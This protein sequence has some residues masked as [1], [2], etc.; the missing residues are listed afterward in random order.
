[1]VS[2]FMRRVVSFEVV[3]VVDSRSSLGRTEIAP[4]V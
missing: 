2:M 4:H 1:M 3:A